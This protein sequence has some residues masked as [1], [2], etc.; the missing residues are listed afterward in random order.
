MK[1]GSKVTELCRNLDMAARA[2]PSLDSFLRFL[3]LSVFQCLEDE[4]WTSLNS[5]RSLRSNL[6]SFSFSAV[7]KK[8]TVFSFLKA[9]AAALSF[10][11][12]RSTGLPKFH[13]LHRL[14]PILPL[15]DLF[16]L[17][18]SIFFPIRPKI[19]KQT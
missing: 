15:I 1:L 10:C 4:F 18:S 9:N 5:P 3:S 14:L 2:P 12:K 7:L 11:L 19:P 8:E 17:L 6:Q 16:K 13:L